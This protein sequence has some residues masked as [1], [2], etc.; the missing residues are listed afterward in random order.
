M[1]DRAVHSFMTVRAEYMRTVLQEDP[2]IL[3]VSPPYPKYRIL[4]VQSPGCSILHAKK[5]EVTF[6]ERRLH[7]MKDYE[8]QDASGVMAPGNENASG[9]SSAPGKQK[10]N[11]CGLRRLLL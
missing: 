4:P 9:Q 10:N 11:T 5:P 6:S 3:A 7:V 8:H 2:G 1:Y